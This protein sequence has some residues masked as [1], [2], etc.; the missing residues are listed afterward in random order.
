MPHNPFDIW[1]P[2]NRDPTENLA[3]SAYGYTQ[4]KIE[5]FINELA[6]ED[7]P[8]DDWVQQRIAID[9]GINLD[10]L[11]NSEIEYIEREVANRRC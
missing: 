10:H 11:T 3:F 2:S 1:A 4:Q 7:D 9:V 6:K 5:D 8:N